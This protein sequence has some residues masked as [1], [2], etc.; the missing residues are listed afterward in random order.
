MTWCALDF[1]VVN[2]SVKVQVVE[3]SVSR[4]NEEYFDDD[5]HDH[6]SDDDDDAKT[7]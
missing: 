5:D 1:H 6:D 3:Y 2:N 7:L 4:N